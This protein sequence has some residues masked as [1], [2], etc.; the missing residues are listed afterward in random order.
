MKNFQKD[1]WNGW[2][3]R[4]GPMGVVCIQSNKQLWNDQPIRIIHDGKLYSNALHQLKSHGIPLR[5]QSMKLQIQY[6]FRSWIAPPVLQPRMPSRG[7]E[8]KE[9][10][11]RN[12][13]KATIH[14]FKPKYESQLQSP[15]VWE[16]I[17]H[18]STLIRNKVAQD[19][20]R[21][22]S[23]LPTRLSRRH[24]LSFDDS[25]TKRPLVSH[26]TISATP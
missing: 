4:C 8:P 1:R 13:A 15:S 10:T 24:S 3:Y 9:Q 21:A 20:I 17:A 22:I 12:P 18:L 2:T 5:I 25:T 19:S 16:P 6:S 23:L 14:I 26:T 7:N 11:N